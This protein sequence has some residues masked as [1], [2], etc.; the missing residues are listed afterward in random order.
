MNISR[1]ESCKVYAEQFLIIVSQ[2]QSYLMAAL[3]ATINL[4]NVNC[5]ILLCRIASSGIFKLGKFMLKLKAPYSEKIA[6]LKKIHCCSH[7]E[8]QYFLLL[9]MITILVWIIVI[10]PYYSGP[11][12]YGFI[13]KA[14]TLH[15]CYI[16]VHIWTCDQYTTMTSR[17]CSR[18]YSN[19]P[20]R[21]R[22]QTMS[23]N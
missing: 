2:G 8:L 12:M 6:P 19:R 10:T 1:I 15:M 23:R 22:E 9:Y 16:S 14:G 3:I 21:A 5:V 7:M 13:R 11:L 17:R 4:V 18:Q 20:K